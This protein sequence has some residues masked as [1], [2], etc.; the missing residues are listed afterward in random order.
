[1]SI[2]LKLTVGNKVELIACSDGVR[3]EK[4]SKVEELI[5]TMK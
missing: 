2:A 1:M 3:V 4:L 5:R